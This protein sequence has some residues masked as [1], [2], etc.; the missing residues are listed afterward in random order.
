MF[1]FVVIVK[2]YTLALHIRHTLLTKNSAFTFNIQF[3]L[4]SGC[5]KILKTSE[6]LQSATKIKK[7]LPSKFL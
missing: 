3:D 7:Q 1:Y 5:L 4:F 2:D 6:M